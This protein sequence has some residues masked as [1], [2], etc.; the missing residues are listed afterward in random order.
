M[1]LEAVPRPKLKGGLPLELHPPLLEVPDEIK[2]EPDH[3][4]NSQT[5]ILLDCQRIGDTFGGPAQYL[6]RRITTSEAHASFE[7]LLRRLRPSSD[8]VNYWRPGNRV[9]N[10]Q[11]IQVHPVTMGWVPSVTTKP[12]PYPKTFL[13]L[14]D[15]ILTHYF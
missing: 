14:A 15:G 12:M 3:E 11:L 4:Q 9:H 10:G 8:L 5:R 6:N 2:N 13:A 7:S 1:P